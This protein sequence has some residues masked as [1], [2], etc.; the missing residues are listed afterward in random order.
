VGLILVS[1][2]STFKI[3]SSVQKINLCFESALEETVRECVVAKLSVAF[4]GLSEGKKR[5][6]GQRPKDGHG[7]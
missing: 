3:N 4:E 6:K 5:E 1:I 7:F 2:G